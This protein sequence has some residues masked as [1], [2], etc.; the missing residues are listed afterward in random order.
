MGHAGLDASLSLSY[1]IVMFTMPAI[2][3]WADLHA[4]KKRLLMGAT[5][6]CVLATAAL[7]WTPRWPAAPRASRWRVIVVVSNTFYS[8]GESLTG[9]FLPELATAERMGRVSGWGWG[10][11]YVGGMLTLGLCLAYVL[12]AQAKRPAGGALRAGHDA[13]HRADLR[14]WLPAS[15]S[16]CCPSARSRRR[17]AREARR[18]GSCA[19]PSGKPAPIATSC[20]CWPAPSATRAAWR[21]PS[22]WR[23]SMPSR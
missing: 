17:R 11:G 4:A 14:R 19:R 16:R 9:A 7:A 10:F 8:Y 18:C 2:G 21:W 13:D 12:W 15:P 5:A 1:A 3:A 23:P 6:G 22:R 20:G